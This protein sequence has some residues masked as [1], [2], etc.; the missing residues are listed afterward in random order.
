MSDKQQI[1]PGEGWFIIDPEKAGPK[2]ATDEYFDGDINKWMKVNEELGFY[3]TRAYRR[4]RTPKPEAC[5]SATEKCDQCAG[6]GYQ[7]GGALGIQCP[8]CHGTGH[9]DEENLSGGVESSRHHPA[10]PDGPTAKRH[11]VMGDDRSS[12]APAGTSGEPSSSLQGPVC[13]GVH[14]RSSARPAQSLSADMPTEEQADLKSAGCEFESHSAHSLSGGAPQGQASGSAT[15]GRDAANG[16]NETLKAGESEDAASKSPAHAAQ[17]EWVLIESFGPREEDFCIK[18]M[19]PR[20]HL[21]HVRAREILSGG[22]SAAQMRSELTVDSGTTPLTGS[23]D[24][25]QSNSRETE[26]NPEVPHIATAAQPSPDAGQREEESL[27]EST[28]TLYNFTEGAMPSTAAEPAKAR[29]FWINIHPGGNIY[30]RVGRTRREAKQQGGKLI[31]TVLTMEVLP[32]APSPEKSDNFEAFFETLHLEGFD[33]IRHRAKKLIEV[34]WSHQQA[35]I[36]DLMRRLSYQAK[37]IELYRDESKADLAT[38]RAE[39]SE[40]K[41]RLESIKNALLEGIL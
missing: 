36:D 27:P 28:E 34:A 2:L 18:A 24:S 37:G 23:H 26:S 5:V 15:K 9:L 12:S 39:N 22:E 17:R 38:L 35:K 25:Q 11:A 16:L 29:E 8:T 10:L 40:M 41:T 20:I 7:I 31:E 6:R 19:G 1:D 30:G 21:A 33:H 13:A 14:S 3:E 32:S 4:R